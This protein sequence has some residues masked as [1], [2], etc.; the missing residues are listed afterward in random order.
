MKG[1]FSPISFPGTKTLNSYAQGKNEKPRPKSRLFDTKFGVSEGT[2]N[3]SDDPYP[4]SM[5]PK[6]GFEPPRGLP[7]TPSRWRVYQFHHFG[8]I[9]ILR[10]TPTA[11][12]PGGWNL[13]RIDPERRFSVSPSM[14]RPGAVERVNCRILNIPFPFFQEKR[15]PPSSIS[16]ALP[17]APEAEPGPSRALQERLWPVLLSSRKRLFGSS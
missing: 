14:A 6:G 8:T 16:L 3:G 4:V 2:P 7:T 9:A 1:L 10:L 15:R 11:L 12:Q 5:V 13:L 17:P